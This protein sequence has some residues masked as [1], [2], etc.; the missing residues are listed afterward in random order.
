MLSGRVYQVMDSN[1]TERETEEREFRPNRI[2][3]KIKL[4]R[5]TSFPEVTLKLIPILNSTTVQTVN[6]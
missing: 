3:V 5:L 2:V 4:R 1:S 6:R